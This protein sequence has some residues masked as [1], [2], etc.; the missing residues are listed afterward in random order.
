MGEIATASQMQF[1]HHAR[2][3]PTTS[4]WVGKAENGVAIHR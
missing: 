1:A 3:L 2:A 4:K